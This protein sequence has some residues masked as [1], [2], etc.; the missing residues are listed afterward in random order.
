MNI[1]VQLE[2]ASNWLFN[3]N[4]KVKTKQVAPSQND[5]CAAFAE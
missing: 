2:T 1:S 4:Q 3:E 5:T